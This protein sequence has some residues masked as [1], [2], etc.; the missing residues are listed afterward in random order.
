LTPVSLSLCA[1]FVNDPTQFLDSGEYGG[2]RD[3]VRGSRMSDESCQRRLARAR[4]PPEN[5]RMDSL[6]LDHFAQKAP[7]ADEVILTDDIA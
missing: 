1:C 2:E 7:G 4:R 6:P 3:E 5:H